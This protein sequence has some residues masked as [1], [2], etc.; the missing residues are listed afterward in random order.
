MPWTL[1]EL[2]RLLWRLVFST[3]QS[4]FSVWHWSIWRRQKQQRSRQCHYRLAAQR[5]RPSQPLPITTELKRITYPTVL[6]DRQW[7][8]AHRV[9]PVYSVG[10]PCTI[11]LRQVLNALFY[12]QANH[13]SWRML[14]GHF[15]CWQTVSSYLYRWRRQGVWETICEAIRTTQ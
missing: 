7:A 13:C 1:P 6:S 11:D 12:M 2:K 5:A 3:S 8:A 15:P 9:I 14:P 4:P 10:R